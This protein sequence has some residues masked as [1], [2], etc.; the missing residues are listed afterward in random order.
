MAVTL[1]SECLVQ[2]PP[3]LEWYRTVLEFEHW[4]IF[5]FGRVAR[6]GFELLLILM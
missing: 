3:I 2:R 5:D 6:H 1:S 4:G